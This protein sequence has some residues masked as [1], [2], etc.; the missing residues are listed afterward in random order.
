MVEDEP[1]IKKLPAIVEDFVGRNMEC[2]NII[3]MINSNRYVSIE[4]APG[5][6]KSA[7][8][9]HVANMMYDRGMFEDGILYLNLRDCNSLASQI[10]KM[11]LAI[12]YFAKDKAIIE[13]EEQNNDDSE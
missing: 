1:A 11:Y 2:K 5:I 3:E 10:K 4:G 6:G 8:A 13:N 7:I 9:K 12:K